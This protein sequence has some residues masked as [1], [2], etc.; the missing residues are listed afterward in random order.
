VGSSW[1]SSWG[2][3]DGAAQDPQ[4]PSTGN[5]SNP[6]GSDPK[7]FEY[8]ISTGKL[9]LVDDK[10]GAKSL[11]GTGYSGNGSAINNPNDQNVSG[12]GPV[13][14]GDYTLGGLHDSAKT[15]KDVM[16]L[17]P[18]PDNDMYGRSAFEM[19]GDNKAQNFTASD[20]CI[21]MT[22]A[23]RDFVGSSGV[24]DLRVVQ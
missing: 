1:G 8:E 16:N 7:H 5:T 12:H 3:S 22:K 13:P 6:Y 17:T 11:V 23:V 10:T 20:G 21:I 19:H 2:G 14:E 4:H 15:G 24:T 18:S 9:Y